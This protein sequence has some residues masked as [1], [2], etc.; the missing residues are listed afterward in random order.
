[1]T[2]KILICSLMLSMAISVH[3]AAATQQY[4]VTNFDTVRMQAPFHV[5]IVTGQ[6]NSARA[7]GERD[8]LDRVSLNVSGGVLTIRAAPPRFGQENGNSGKV[9]VIITTA[10]L[11]RVLMGGNGVLTINGMK[12]TR[13]DVNLAGNGDLEINGVALDQL[14]VNSAGSGRIRLAG[15]AGDARV[16]VIG[17]GSIEAP[18]FIAKTLTIDSQGPGSI[19]LAATGTADVTVKGSGDV[20]VRGRPACKTSQAGSGQLICGSD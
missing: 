9:S 15:K 16:Q 3:A 10:T 8:A 11:R 19:V 1:M 4:S 6:G 20:T 13:G 7:E 14:V 5:T 18:E 2:M 12:G 17:A